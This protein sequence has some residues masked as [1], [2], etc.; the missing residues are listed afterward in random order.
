[1]LLAKAVPCQLSPVQRGRMQVVMGEGLQLP[2]VS[3][4]WKEAV[5]ELQSLNV[6]DPE[7]KSENTF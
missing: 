5:I 1:M 2:S 4:L 7:S 6:L 3:Q